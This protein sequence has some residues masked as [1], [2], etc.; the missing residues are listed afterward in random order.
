MISLQ[1]QADLLTQP[2]DL[3]NFD[4]FIRATLFIV[5]EKYSYLCV[6]INQRGQHHC[7]N[8]WNRKLQNC[9]DFVV[10]KTL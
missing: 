4:A 1:F 2:N 6:D 10:L 8:R 7:N 9:Y 3:G 5:F